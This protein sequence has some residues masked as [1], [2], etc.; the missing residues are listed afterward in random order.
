MAP[1]HNIKKGA[2]C[3]LPPGGKKKKKKKAGKDGGVT[4]RD[5]E[6]PEQRGDRRQEPAAVSL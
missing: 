4:S 5:T 3:S 6:Q 2:M 1:G